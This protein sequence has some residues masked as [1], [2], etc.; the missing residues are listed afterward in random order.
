MSSK[1]MKGIVC[2]FFWITIFVIAVQMVCL[3]S[4]NHTYDSLIE[5][6]NKAFQMLSRGQRMPQPGDPDFNERDMLLEKYTVSEVATLNLAAPHNCSRYNWSLY[7]VEQTNS[8]NSSY[9]EKRVLNVRMSNG[10]SSATRE[11]VCYIPTSNLKVD[12]Y[13][14]SL[15]VEGN[16]GVTY[17]DSCLVV[18]HRH[19]Q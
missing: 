14:L 12:T 5:E 4:C 13:R 18:I 10:T 16:D 6:Y 3:T 9:S 1:R 8:I 19:L 17:Q 15:E 7:E 2:I 11:F